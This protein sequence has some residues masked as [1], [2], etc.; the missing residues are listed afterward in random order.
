M[1]TPAPAS[2]LS[3]SFADSGQSLTGLIT[4]LADNADVLTGPTVSVSITGGPAQTLGD[5]TYRASPSSGPS[6]DAGFSTSSGDFI[7][8]EVPATQDFNNF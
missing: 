1:L 8:K 3:F 7:L 4:G 6:G 2:A 5:Y